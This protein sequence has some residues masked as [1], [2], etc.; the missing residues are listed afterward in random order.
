MARTPNGTLTSTI[1]RIRAGR[2]GSFR[3][4][5]TLVVI[6][7]AAATPLSASGEGAPSTADTAPTGVT[8]SS[9]GPRQIV[10][11]WATQR[12]APG[13]ADIPD[14]EARAFQTSRHHIELITGNSNNR[15]FVGPTLNGARQDCAVVLG[16]PENPDPAVFAD[17]QWIASTYATGPKTVYALIHDEYHGWQHPGECPVQSQRLVVRCWYNAITLAVSHDGGAHYVRVGRPGYVF[18]VPSRYASGSGPVGIFT[19]SNIV[20]NPADGYYYVLGYVNV[21]QRYIGSCL[22]RTRRLG[23]PGSWRAWNGTS[24]AMRFVDPYAVQKVDGRHL[25]PPVTAWTPRDLQPDSITYNTVAHQWLLIGMAASGVY[26]SLSPDLI[27]WSQPHLFYRAQVT[28]NLR[29]GEPDPIAY[30][31]LLD[32][33]SRSRNF[34]TSGTTAY[35]YFTLLHYQCPL[36]LPQYDRDLVRV[37]V[38]IRPAG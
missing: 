26:Y 20:R 1:T 24:F 29:C 9:T 23:S 37:P 14:A 11:D 35:L 36:T 3:I 38:E 10:F 25:C 22:M 8:V 6:A 15:R 21:R 32:P 33:A 30:P 18:G 28:W 17:R 19:V 2:T 27:T 34:E 31:S 5:A 12:C 7:L 16:S 4:I 13:D